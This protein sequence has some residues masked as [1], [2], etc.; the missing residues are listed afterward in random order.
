MSVFRC[1]RSLDADEKRISL[2]ASVVMPDHVHCLFTLRGTE[3]LPATIKCLKG[4]SAQLVNESLQRRGPVWQPGYY[5]HLL[6]PEDRLELVL[7]Y[8][9]NNPTPAGSNFHC[10]RDTWEWFRGCVI[11][12]PPRV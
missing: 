7:R 2:V 1:L 9:W 4:R 6:R 11:D 3:T 10:A 5:D 8:M 12:S